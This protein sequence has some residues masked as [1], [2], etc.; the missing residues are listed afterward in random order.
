MTWFLRYV[1]PPIAITALSIGLLSLAASKLKPKTEDKETIAVI[2]AVEVIVAQPQA[3]Q[4]EVPSQGVVQAR[5]Q[6]TLI[7]DVS[8]RVESVSPVLSA[9]GSFRAGD[10]LATIEDIDYQVAL[11]NARSRLAEADLAHQQEQA[12]AEQAIEDW[13]AAARKEDPSDLVLR[14]PQLARTKA[15]LE[16]A[17]AAV[18]LAERDLRRTKVI[19]PY[20]GRVRQKFVDVGQMLAARASQIATV[21]ATEAAEVRLP[22]SLDDTRY[23]DLPD[24]SAADNLPDVIIEANIAGKIWQ[25]PAKV[26]RSEGALD[27][28]TRLLYLVASLENPF[29]NSTDPEKPSLKVGMFVTARLQGHQLEDVFVLPRKALRPGDQLFVAD[30]ESRLSIRNA[31]V[32]QKNEDT[33]IVTGGLEPGERIVLTPL[34]YAVSGM[35]LQPIDPGN[36]GGSPAFSDE[37]DKSGRAARVPREAGP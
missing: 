22:I 18:A 31:T 29:Q 21:Y 25:W 3:T 28:R 11:A 34:E 7:A 30:E 20:D 32:Y 2:P 1:A 23:L 24:D 37:T 26:A 33:V 35:Q 9:G 16:A 17:Q 36:A 5:T 14:K 13:K 6:T 19:A 27:T 8:G 15:N 12:L 4:V 10:T